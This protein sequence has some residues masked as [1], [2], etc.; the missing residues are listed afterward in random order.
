MPTENPT[1]LFAAL[2]AIIVLVA[3]LARPT[4]RRSFVN[5]ARCLG[6]HPDLWR[7]PAAFTVGYAAFQTFAAALLNARLGLNMPLLAAPDLPPTLG[8]LLAAEWLP[9]AERTAT[10]FSAFV[11]TFP[12]AAWFALAFLVN[13][14]GLLGELRRALR[15]RFG[16]VLGGWLL[17]GVT[18]AAIAAI[19]RPA[20]YLLL[21]ELAPHAPWY[22]P[23]VVMV[24]GAAFE[25]GLGVYFLTYLML[26]T[27]TWLRGIHF[28]RP[29]LRRLAMRRTGYVLKWSLVLAA[30]T[31]LFVDAPTLAGLLLAGAEADPAGGFVTNVGRPLV[32]AFAFA[33]LPVA[34]ILAFH[35][36]SL[37]AAAR[38]GIRLILR[39]AADLAPFLAAAFAL[40]FTL[41]V[42]TAAAAELVGAA[43]IADHA[44]RVIAALIEGVLAGWLIASWV[45]LYK[46]L[47]TRRKETS[48]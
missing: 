36:E 8:P 25:L 33:A 12:L 5:A 1:A 46:S 31:I 20:V 26:M 4:V 19:L 30:A 11:A 29:D 6:R 7:I 39:H 41:R 43:T 40:G 22:A 23:G 9:A 18:L 47:P 35:N 21:P 28:E 32:A 2:A 13:A 17:A 24:I 38:E 42:A 45:C 37:R 3:V 48:S 10:L 27:H 15:S 34:A 14:G 16:P 44:M